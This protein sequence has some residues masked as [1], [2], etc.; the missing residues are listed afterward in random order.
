MTAD[1]RNVKVVGA[2]IVAMTLGAAVLLFLEPYPRGWSSEPMLIAQTRRVLSDLTVY[3]IPHAAA[4]EPS[5][6]D[7][8]VYED[9]RCEWRP[10]GGPARLAVLEGADQRMS[11][12]Q[13]R[14]LLSLLYELDRNHELAMRQIRLEPYSDPRLYSGLSQHA[15]DLCDWLVLKRFIR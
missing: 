3:H 12:E 1:N 6:F 14:A 9:G 4:F 15:R 11:G 8:V 2:L 5:A 7:G 13:K 10:A